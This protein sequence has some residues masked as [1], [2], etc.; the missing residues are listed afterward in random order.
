MR[1]R[2]TALKTQTTAGRHNL[3]YGLQQQQ[4][5]SRPNRTARPVTQLPQPAH[6][7]LSERCARARHGCALRASGFSGRSRASAHKRHPRSRRDRLDQR[8]LGRLELHSGDARA[9]ALGLR[10]ENAHG[11]RSRRRRG[12]ERL[13]R[14]RLARPKPRPSH[15]ALGISPSGRSARRLHASCDESAPRGRAIRRHGRHD[16]RRACRSARYSKS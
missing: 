14:P 3:K 7:T 11:R 1:R 15:R 2:R 6:R 8:Q 9:A 5:A 12:R 16:R 13:E 10:A 4:H